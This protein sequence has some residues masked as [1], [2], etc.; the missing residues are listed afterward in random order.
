M[1]QS[2][3][4]DEIQSKSASANSQSSAGASLNGVRLAAGPKEP[5][6][7]T[8]RKADPSPEL[9]SPN[10]YVTTV[11]LDL[12][13]ERVPTQQEVSGQGAMCGGLAPAAPA[14]PQD[15]EDEVDA[16]LRK[17][18]FEQGL[19]TKLPTPEE[20]QEL[21]NRGAAAPGLV[22]AAKRLDEGKKKVR[23]AR[24]QNRDFAL[25]M[26]EWNATDFKEAEKALRAYVKEFKDSPWTPEALIH[27]ADLA[28]FNGQPNEAE[29]GYKKV[30]AM[31]SDDTSKL[32]YEAHLKAY[33]R[34]ADLY[35]LEG[36]LGEARLMLGNIVQDDVHWRRRTW[37]QY[38]SMQLNAY[39]AGSDVRLADLDCGTKA[40]AALLVDLGRSRDA[41]RVAAI[42]PKNAKGFSLAELKNIA[43]KEKV[44]MVGF[45]ATTDALAQMPLP[46]I[47][48]YS[49]PARARAENAKVAPKSDRDYGHYVV[50][51]AYDASRGVW[52]VFNPQDGTSVTLDA[53]Q[54]AKEWS[55]AGLMLARP[56]AK[57]ALSPERER[58]RWLALWPRDGASGNEKLVSSEAEVKT[59]ALAQL[60]ATPAQREL[61]KVALLSPK[62]MRRIVGTCYVVHANS[63][64]GDRSFKLG[65]RTPCGP[66]GEPSVSIDPVDQNI[67]VTDTPIWYNPAKGPKVSFNMAYNSLLASNY[68]GTI[69]NKWTH[70]YG[71]FL[72]EMLGQVT[73]FGGDGS[74]DVYT[75]NND[76]SYKSPPG[77]Y[78]RLSKTGT[79]TFALRSQ[80]GDTEYYGIPAGQNSTV[81]MLLEQRDRWGQSL[82]IQYML[83]GGKLVPW[84][85][86]DADGKITDFTYSS[87]R[88]YS[89]RVPDGRRAY[90]GYDGNGNLTSCQDVAGQSFT[91]TYDSMIVLTQ[92]NTPQGPWRFVSENQPFTGS[93][94]TQAYNQIKV[95]DPLNTL[96]MIVRYDNKVADVPNYTSTDHRGKTTRFGVQTVGSIGVVN[97][98]TTPE[99]YTQ[100]LNYSDADPY[101]PIYTRGPRTNATLEYNAEGNLTRSISGINGNTYINRIL[102]ID[103]QGG[104]NVS[105]V[106]ATA[107]LGDSIVFQGLGSA[108]NYSNYQPGLVTDAAGNRASIIYNAW[109]APLT[110]TTYD[111][112]NGQQLDEVRYVY[113]TQAGL[114]KDRVIEM[115]LNTT[116]Q[117]SYTYDSAGRVASMTDVRGIVVR[118][119]YNALDNLTQ[120]AYPDNT[121]ETTTYDCCSLP[122]RVTDRSGRSTSYGYD[123]LKRLTSVQ[124]ADDRTLKFGYDAE[125]NRTSLR[126][127]RV[128]AGGAGGALTQWT[129]DGDGRAVRKTYADNTFEQWNYDGPT[130]LL[131]SSVN[132]RKQTTRYG[133]SGWND[134]T[135]IDYVA[136]PNVGYFRDSFGRLVEMIDGTGSTK[137]SYDNAGRPH[138]EDGPWNGDTIQHYYD[139]RNNIRRIEAGGDAVNY[140]Y[141][142][143]GRLSQVSASTSFG[144]NITG[145]RGAT[146]DTTYIGW[147]QM[148]ATQTRPNG[149]TTEWRY[150]GYGTLQRMAV[151][152][153]KV[154]ANSAVLTSFGYDYGSVPYGGTTK[155]LDMDNRTGM[156]KQ[157]G[158]NP[159]TA[160]SSG[161]SYNRTSMMTQE[162]APEN[163][164]AATPLVGRGHAYDAMGNRT[165]FY[166]SYSQANFTFAYNNLNQIGAS[167][168][169]VPSGDNL[170]YDHSYDADGNMLSQLHSYDGVSAPSFGT[171]YTWD[172]ENRLTSVSDVTNNGT[173]VNSKTEFVYDGMSRLRISRYYTRQSNGTLALQNE[174]R[175]VYDGMEIVQERDGTNVVTASLTRTGNIGGI[176]ARTTQ[177]GS[178]FYGYDGSGNVVT[179][180][181][182]LG[183]EVGSYNYDAFGNPL[184]QS[185]V[186]ADANPYRFSTKEQIAG[187]YSYGFRF[188]SPGSGRWINRDPIGEAGGVNLY[189]FA[190]NDPVNL[191]DA[192]GLTIQS[193]FGGVWRSITDT[194][195]GLYIPLR[196]RYL[197]NPYEKP[198]Y[199]DNDPEHMMGQDVT[200]AHGDMVSRGAGMV[201]DGINL[202]MAICPVGGEANAAKSFFEGTT[203]TPKVLKQIA[204]GDNHAFPELVRDFEKHGVV[205]FIVGGDGIARARLSIPG[206]INGKAGVFEYIKEADGSI[207]HHFFNTKRR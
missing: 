187:L 34:W 134:L 167:H 24:K 45:R 139:G 7:K 153:N 83:Y 93:N 98:M 63:Q 58:S 176:L 155:T 94:G 117:A 41:R 60:T 169:T 11:P 33:E 206:T 205:D 174:K 42:D 133:Y 9:W 100:T 36:R 64:N 147:S 124:D 67:F 198:S 122:S 202:E 165:R 18:G 20:A 10:D 16:I 89:I 44:E 26:K 142:V 182:R 70:N 106:L 166:D 55:G 86:T 157:Y 95:Y 8:T 29:E 56:A 21:V 22:V 65:A 40:L 38:W 179:L 66:K 118:Y 72:T 92:L 108:T 188:Y 3:R 162:N 88:L 126:D 194:G 49:P 28:K 14:E 116:L 37:A 127:A 27:L 186:A 168:M 113:G 140:G 85:L 101:Q 173:Q 141:D 51:R 189:A 145:A 183:A 190:K 6:D 43:G 111:G 96:P 47:L 97:G 171:L 90:F 31:T 87:G 163:G 151:M 78:T 199:V 138:I 129:Y 13:D 135:N 17:E 99:G 53:K 5:K 192:Y 204:S 123:N 164:S 1:L 35:L 175:R 110:V 143:I 152:T 80:Q 203:Y 195:R 73:R 84:T 150:E 128:D 50:V 68:N 144:G 185:G 109:G 146:W 15:V 178:V 181:D 136:T 62:E 79:H 103:Y 32:S 200:T 82:T 160:Q 197:G 25:A 61:A 114:N 54:L 131:V 130:G 52:S 191:G 30:L 180:T 137:W 71:A 4:A 48:H 119:G 159:N 75:Q 148:P 69:G 201:E 46:M 12:S 184:S 149:G 120:T 121:S 170:S 77:V 125:G 112:Q 39:F 76:G 107:S 104:V 158:N 193:L 91:Y 102:R 132:A 172:E 57:T 156:F 2:A 154:S 74:Q 81:P 161:F 115:R 23:K 196:D 177:A 59:R 19:K 105:G 207:N